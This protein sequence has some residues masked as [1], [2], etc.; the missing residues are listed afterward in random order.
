[1]GILLGYHFVVPKFSYIVHT[2]YQQVQYFV[3]LSF[4][5][6]SYVSATLQFEFNYALGLYL[7]WI[8]RNLGFPPRI[9]RSSFVNFSRFDTN[10]SSR[11]W[12]VRFGKKM[13]F[14]LLNFYHWS[15]LCLKDNI[16]VF[17]FLERLTCCVASSMFLV[18]HFF[19]D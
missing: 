8:R 5:T 14:S 15:L 9:S 16:G 18:C 1:M 19:L 13:L 3:G 6:T 4:V 7:L 10:R 12:V 17:V 2:T 11:R